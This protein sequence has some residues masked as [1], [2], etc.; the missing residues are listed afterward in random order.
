MREEREV[1]GDRE[2]E[3]IGRRG[4][5]EGRRSREG[6]ERGREESGREESGRGRRVNM[7]NLQHT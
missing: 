1:R 3:E 4:E 2:W 7:Q 6:E 5:R